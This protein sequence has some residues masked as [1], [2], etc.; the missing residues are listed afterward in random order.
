[1]DADVEISDDILFLACTRPAMF[2]GA[3]I[4]AVCLNVILTT[5]LFLALG[6]IFYAAVGAILHVIARSIVRH[7]HNAFRVLS[8]WAETKGRHRNT[9]FWGGSSVTPLRLVR[10]Y[11]E[12]DL[13]DG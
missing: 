11:G 8:G 5:L 6:S 4:E 1:M 3:T 2:A 7:D 13:N 10:T 9:V 12:R